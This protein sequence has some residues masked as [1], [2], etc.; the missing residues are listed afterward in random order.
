MDHGHT[1]VLYLAPSWKLSAKVLEELANKQTPIK[2][3]DRYRC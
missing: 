2:L 3:N 1:N